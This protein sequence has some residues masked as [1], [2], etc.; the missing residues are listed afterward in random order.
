MTSKILCGAHAAA[1]VLL[2]S[3]NELRNNKV[4]LY[5]PLS[6]ILKLSFSIASERNLAYHGYSK[7]KFCGYKTNE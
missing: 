5:Q 1:R 4:I 3:V 6:N 7:P 2:S